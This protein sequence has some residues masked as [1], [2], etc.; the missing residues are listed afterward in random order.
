MNDAPETFAT[1][2]PLLQEPIPLSLAVLPQDVK[3]SYSIR[4]SVGSTRTV[5]IVSGLVF[6]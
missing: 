6:P 5:L 4:G 3:E 2:V 1:H